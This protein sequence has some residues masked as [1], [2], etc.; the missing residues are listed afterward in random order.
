M[1]N[2]SAASEGLSRDQKSSEM[3]AATVPNSNRAVHLAALTRFQVPGRSP[4]WLKMKNLAAP[5]VKR[6]AEED[7]GKEDGD[8]H[9]ENSLHLPRRY[10]DRRM[11]R[12]PPLPHL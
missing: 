9:D 10:L 3:F 11:Q 5:A 6:E 7:W 12:E 1:K 8:D 2:G 4:D